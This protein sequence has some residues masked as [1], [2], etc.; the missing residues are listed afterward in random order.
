MCRSKTQQNTVK[1]VE[2]HR[3]EGKAEEVQRRRTYGKGTNRRGE[4]K[5]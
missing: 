2:P 1:T 4:Y 5:K 3:M